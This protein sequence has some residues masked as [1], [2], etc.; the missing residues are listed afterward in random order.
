MNNERKLIRH[1]VPVLFFQYAFDVFML[2]L[3]EKPRERETERKNKN[4]KQNH[5]LEITEMLLCVGTAHE[6]SFVNA[7]M[8]IRYIRNE[9][10]DIYILY[11]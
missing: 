5:Y 11:I 2:V 1:V 8:R 7:R 10:F 9:A 3:A 6:F 4:T